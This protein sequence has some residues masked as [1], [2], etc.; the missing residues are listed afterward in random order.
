MLRKY[1]K[2]DFS[3]LVISIVTGE[4]TYKN[5]IKIKYGFNTSHI[6]SIHHSHVSLKKHVIC[7]K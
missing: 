2:V 3:N 5:V 4:L 7:I 6:K 1:K